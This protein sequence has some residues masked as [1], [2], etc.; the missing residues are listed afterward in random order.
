VR[1]FRA[2]DREKLFQV[3][4]FKHARQA[5]CG[6]DWNVTLSRAGELSD[7]DL[8]KLLAHY[9]ESQA[10]SSNAALILHQQLGPK[11]ARMIAGE[12]P[13]SVLHTAA[14]G[15]PVPDATRAFQNA[16]AGYVAWRRNEGLTKKAAV[17][18][19]ARLLKIP[20]DELLNANRAPHDVGMYGSAFALLAQ[21]NGKTPAQVLKAAH[22][23]HISKAKKKPKKAARGK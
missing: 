17:G 22:A 7:N 20:A 18:E 10:Q 1:Y 6:E 2:D 12:S 15:R 3:H 21:M 16:T 11:L 8:L 9:L 13:R 5:E 14:R 4:Q 23:A 19:A